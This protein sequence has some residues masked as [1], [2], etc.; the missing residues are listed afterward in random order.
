MGELIAGL[1]GCNRLGM[2]VYTVH[3]AFLTPIGLGVPRE[4]SLRTARRRFAASTAYPLTRGQVALEE[5]CPGTFRT[6][7]T[8]QALVRAGR[9]DDLSFCLDVGHANTGLLPEFM[10]LKSRLA[11]L[12]VHDNNGKF[13]E[14][15]PIGDGTVDFDS[16]S[17]SLPITAGGIVHRVPGIADA[18]GQQG[19]DCP[20]C[21]T[22]MLMGSPL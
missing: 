15:L 6:G 5:T 3:P 11:N 20:R 17:A 8:P 16:W 12:H 22:A 2:D 19:T 21:W 14:H 13:D 7:T 18:H 4:R 9:R 1:E 10:E